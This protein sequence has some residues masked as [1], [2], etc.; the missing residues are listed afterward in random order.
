MKRLIV[1]TNAWVRRC[2]PISPWGGLRVMDVSPHLLPDLFSGQPLV[3]TGR[4]TQPASGTVHLKGTR[5]GGPFTRDIPVMLSS[6]TRAFDALA[7]YWARRRID[8][9]MSQDWLGMQRGAM[10][11][12]LQAQITQ[13]GL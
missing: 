7:G 5:A 11:P 1:S 3:I 8:D 13:L 10:K 6:S 12:E 9:L 4:Y 2:R